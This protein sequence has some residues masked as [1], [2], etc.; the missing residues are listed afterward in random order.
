MIL[1]VLGLGSPTSPLDTGAWDAWTRTYAWGSFG[2]EEHVG[3][4]PLFGHQ[5]SH[6]WIDFREIQDAYMRDRGIDYFENSRRATLAQRAYAIRNP[7][8]FADYGENVWGLT[9][10]ARPAQRPRTASGRLRQLSAHTPRDAP[11]T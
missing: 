5:Y 10:G 3:F 8:G 1:Y 2:G 9:A 4:G 11:P 6:V 7:L